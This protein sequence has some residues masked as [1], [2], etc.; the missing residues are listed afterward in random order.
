MGGRLVVVVSDF[1]IDVSAL[2]VA[3]LGFAVSMGDGLLRCTSM[4]HPMYH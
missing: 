1:P 4:Y 3:L 2:V